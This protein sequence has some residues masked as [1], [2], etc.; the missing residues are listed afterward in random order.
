MMKGLLTALTTL[1]F[2]GCAT[3]SM[4]DVQ[5]ELNRGGFELWYPA[6]AGVQPGEVW[7]ISSEPK[8]EPVQ[9]KPQ[10]LQVQ[11]P[12][13]S[14]FRTLK[15]TISWGLSGQAD[16]PTIA[17]AES[18][19]AAFDLGGVKKVDL[20]FGETEIYRIFTGDLT[21]ESNIQ[22][23]GRDYLEALLSART[24]EN[25]A[26]LSSV[27]VSKGLRFEILSTNQAQLTAQIPK[28]EQLFNARL[29]V[30]NNNTG[31]AVWEI[32]NTN[33]LIIAF[34]RVSPQNLENL[35]RT[36]GG[37]LPSS[38]PQNI[39][40]IGERLVKLKSAAET[41]KTLLPM[42]P[43]PFELVVA[44][45]DFEAAWKNLA[46]KER[47]ML[48]QSILFDWLTNA[49]AVIRIQE[50]FD[51]KKQRTLNL[52]E[53]ALSYYSEAG[54][55]EFH[56][57]L[58]LQKGNVYY[59]LV[60]QEHTDESTFRQLAS[61]GESTMQLAS[62]M[63]P[64]SMQSSVL[65]VW[66]KFLYALARPQGF[67]LSGGWSNQY[68]LLAYE[69]IRQ[70]YDLEPGDLKNTTQLARTVQRL[71]ANPPQDK[72]PIW[73]QNMGESYHR[74]KAGW[75]L[76]K[77]ALRN[78]EN[79]VA[80]LNI[81]GVLGMEYVNRVWK[82]SKS[83][84]RK[85]IANDLLKELEETVIPAQTDALADAI[86][87]GYKQFTFDLNYDLGR[88][89]MVGFQ[90]ASNSDKQRAEELWKA[91]ASRF[92]EAYATATAKQSAAAIEDLDRNLTVVDLP[93]SRKQQIR[94]IFAGK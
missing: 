3:S 5:K 54:N 20:N 42:H 65:R 71:A 4:R 52:I 27:V 19:K 72:L 31:E 23:M 40:L 90:I 89:Y 48:N 51:V 32:P 79:R 74:V 9:R 2:I 50:D 77:S 88:I 87:A 38:S 75:E 7:S 33:K 46:F 34:A 58:L 55:P 22:Q 84:T 94:Q 91:G 82:E 73:T 85:K 70:A 24:N 81:I 29:I 6:E 67:R 11:G 66:S 26:V 53:Q 30:T 57:G 68:L 28:V 61:I 36:V 35:P 25:Q 12:H 37:L 39:N 14:Q 43:V 47:T 15:K 69:K 18:L 76:K 86:P 16:Y 80:P 1:L 64:Q 21:A 8:R 45:G 59:D 93:N 56:T 49:I 10:W 41:N 44:A 60:Q 83:P 17:N 13:P 63:A 78:P 92:K 62:Q